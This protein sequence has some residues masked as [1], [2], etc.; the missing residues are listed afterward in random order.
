MRFNQKHNIY[1]FKTYVNINVTCFYLNFKLKTD[2]RVIG[3]KNLKFF[4]KDRPKI[5]SFFIAKIN[6]ETKTRLPINAWLKIL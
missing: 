3:K 1:P 2:S 5:E 6:T 4:L